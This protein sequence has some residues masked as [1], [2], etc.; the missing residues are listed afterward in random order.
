MYKFSNENDLLSSNQSGFRPDESWI[1]QLLSLT[2]EIY[3]SF[4]N[5]L[6]VRGVFL[7]IFKT[8]VKVWHKGVILKLSCNGISGNLQNL[9]KTFL[10]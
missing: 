8:F 3:Q 1:N 5:D 10:K 4:D 7:N 2:H 6:E 9:L